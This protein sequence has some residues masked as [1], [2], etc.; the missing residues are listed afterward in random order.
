MKTDK[1]TDQWRENWQANRGDSLDI[2]ALV[3]QVRR[4]NAREKIIAFFE[5]ASSTVPI[6]LCLFAITMPSSTAYERGFFLLLAAFVGA[7]VFWA[8]RQRRRIWLKPQKTPSELIAWER[9]RLEAKMRYWRVSFWCVFG[10]WLL[11]LLI[12]AA[13]L[14][15][16]SELNRGWPTS[17][18]ANLGVLL[19]T[20]AWL[21]V[22]KHRARRQ[23][24]ALEALDMNAG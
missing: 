4:R 10:I 12:A 23:L 7:F 19:A 18:I 15:S 22:V 8:V 9:Q 3:E 14:M 1:E 2:D 24:D 5:V 21:K 17:A 13:S 20:G 16:N 11:L 6:G